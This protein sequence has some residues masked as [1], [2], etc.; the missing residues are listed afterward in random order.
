MAQR[1]CWYVCYFMSMLQLAALNKILKVF[2]MTWLE[3]NP[4]ITFCMQSRHSTNW[5]TVLVASKLVTDPDPKCQTSFFA[6][7]FYPRPAGNKSLLLPCAREVHPFWSSRQ[8]TFLAKHYWYISYFSMKTFVGIHW[9]L[10]PE[11]ILMSSHMFAQRNKKIFGWLPLL[12][13][14]MMEPRNNKQSPHTG[15]QNII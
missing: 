3:V 9:N 12:S 10:F 15:K 5:A 1:W 13:R 2:G 11:I 14:V 8:D 7:I 6:A 4:T